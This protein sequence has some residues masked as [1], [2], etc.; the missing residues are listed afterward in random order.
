MR[1]VAGSSQIAE[2]KN[3]LLET[4]LEHMKEMKPGESEIIENLQIQ[5]RVAS[6][7]KDVDPSQ[8]PFIKGIF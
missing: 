5:L 1:K 6:E 4:I 2:A 7:P 3:W 8:N